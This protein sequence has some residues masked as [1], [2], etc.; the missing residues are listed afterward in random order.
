MPIA[1]APG[2]VILLAEDDPNI[3][4]TTTDLLSLTGAQV[5]P[6]PSGRAAAA[7]LE[8]HT[9][10]L[11]ITDLIMPDGDGI[12]LLNHVRTSPRH[13][14]LPVIMLTARADVNELAANFKH[15]ADEYLTKP[16]HPEQF[17]NTV[18][19]WLRLPRRSESSPATNG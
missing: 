13:S 11:V 19:R 15:R 14:E 4:E 16:F 5:L 12:W 7:L 18:V 2:T 1:T 3:R 10:D 8:H 17:L 9:V 6:A